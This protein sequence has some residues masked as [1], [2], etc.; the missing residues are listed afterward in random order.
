MTSNGTT[1][2][3]QL[4]N[5][6]IQQQ[7]PSQQLPSQQ[8][9]SQQL[10]QQVPQQLPQLPQQ[11][12]QTQQLPSQQFTT[13]EINSVV[14]NGDTNYNELI[15]QLQKAS[16]SGATSLPTRD[17]PMDMNKINIDNEIKPNY[18]PDKN[19]EIDDYVRN[20]LDKEYLIEENRKMQNNLDSLDI[21]YN[22]LQMPLLL[23]ILFFL[24]NL[25]VMK[26]NMRKYIPALFQNDLNMNIYGHIVYSIMFSSSFYILFKVVNKITN[27]I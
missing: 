8:L 11:M 7:L 12:Q 14:N 25:P 1:S 10:P 22:E 15:N 9:P 6:N 21:L 19:I 26:K 3:M 23:S 17:I 16:S 2:I 18:I 20:N 5:S 13:N 4:P 27:N 24:F